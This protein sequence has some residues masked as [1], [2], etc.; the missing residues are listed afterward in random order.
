[1]YNIGEHKTGSLSSGI[2][3]TA[4]QSSQEASKTLSPN[5]PKK[6]PRIVSKEFSENT[7]KD[8]SR[9]FDLERSR[10]IIM[11]TGLRDGLGV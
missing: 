2:N 3:T 11:S 4:N 1:M 8:V 10:E 9:S 5:F 7:P 6:I